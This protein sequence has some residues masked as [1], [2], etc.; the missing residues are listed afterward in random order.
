M[1]DPE[2]V[3]TFW[4]GELDADGRSDDEHSARWWKKDADFDAT[5]REKF[6]GVH[7]AI[8]RG[9]LSEWL[10]SPRGRLASIVVLDQFSRNMFR[11]TSRAF[12]SDA[13]AVEIALAAVAD[14]ADRQFAH[15]ER[16][17]LYMPLMHCEDP[18]IQDRCVVLFAAWR[19][20]STGK[21]REQLERTIKYAEQHRDIVRRFGRFPHRNAIVGR[22]ST[23]EEIEF[24]KQPGSSF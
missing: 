12:A 19:D 20:E 5:I 7:D 17:F 1:T 23:E 6:G 11:G 22:A 18:T 8:M 9:E 14:G 3:L 24:L 10:S 4:F 2:E 21:E 13:R 15:S 16:A